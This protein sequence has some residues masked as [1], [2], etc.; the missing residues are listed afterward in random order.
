MSIGKVVYLIGQ[1][2][3]G[4]TTLMNTLTAGWES[5]IVNK[6]FAHTVY[7]NGLAQLGKS[8]DAF[9]GTDA[10]AMNVQPA[11][12]KWLA[13]ASYP[14]VLGEG[15]R[16][17]NGKFF[18]AVMGLGIGL[19]VWYLD[20]PSYVA[21]QRRDERGSSQSETWLKGRRTKLNNLLPYVSVERIL[22]GEQ[23]PEALAERIRTE[24]LSGVLD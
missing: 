12:V 21:S 24:A 2:G 23:P 15:D 17:G 9:G 8:R 14:I 10:L 7:A 18:K 3:S 19:Q 13:E 11:V 1:A 5:K 16:L 20:T 22:D 4:K 6:P